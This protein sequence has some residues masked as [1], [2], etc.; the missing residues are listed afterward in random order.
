[1]LIVSN[2]YYSEEGSIKA[3]VIYAVGLEV[4]IIFL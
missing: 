3:I 2:T 1:M 4:N